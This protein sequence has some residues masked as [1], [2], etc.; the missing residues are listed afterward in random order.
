MWKTRKRGT[1]KQI[2]KRFRLGVTSSQQKLKAGLPKVMR[3][4]APPIVDEL[5]ISEPYFGKYIAKHNPRN[6]T[7]TVLKLLPNDKVRIINSGFSSEQKAKEWIAY[8]VR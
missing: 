3:P 1:P 6:D 5:T 4:K 2:G 7:W 8:N